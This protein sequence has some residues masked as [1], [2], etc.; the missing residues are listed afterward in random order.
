M[1][2]I[3]TG[4][5]ALATKIR[6]KQ[7]DAMTDKEP[8]P[9]HDSARARSAIKAADCVASLCTADRSKS[10]KFFAELMTRSELVDLT[11]SYPFFEALALKSFVGEIFFALVSRFSG[12]GRRLHPSASYRSAVFG[13]L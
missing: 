3:D 13:A 2:G 12:C 11:W 1:V 7:Q 4:L 6:I 10:E 8:P 9:S 5:S